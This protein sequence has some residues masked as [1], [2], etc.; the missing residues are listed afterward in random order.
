MQ[1]V[2]WHPHLETYIPLPAE[3]PVLGLEVVSIVDDKIYLRIGSK[4]TEVRETQIALLINH[5]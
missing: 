3:I 1:V 4:I 2:I 5:K